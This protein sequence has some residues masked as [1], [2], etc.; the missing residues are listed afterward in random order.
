MTE[1]SPSTEQATTTG[2]LAPSALVLQVRQT[3]ALR[4]VDLARMLGVS[5]RTVRRWEDGRAVRRIYI[6]RLD[7]M[8]REKERA[9]DAQDAI[10][11]EG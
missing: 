3:L 11:P 2:T 7:D 9:G 5:T 4:Q 1:S 8:L 10:E 6:E